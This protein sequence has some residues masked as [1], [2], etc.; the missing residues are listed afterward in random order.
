MK[1]LILGVLILISTTCFSQKKAKNP[2]TLKALS[3]KYEGDT[4][5]GLA[6]GE[7]KASGSED[8]YEGNFKKG[9][10]HGEGTYIWGNGNKY[11]GEFSKGRMNGEGELFIK[12]KNNIVSVQAGYFK[13]N[14]YLGKYKSPYK[15]LSE[16]GVRSVDF[17]E[18]GTNLNQVTFEVYLNGKMV[19]IRELE[20][21][22]DNS[23]IVADVNGYKALTN[24]VFPLK[25][26]ELSFEI[27]GTTYKVVFEIYKKADWKV[28]ISA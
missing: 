8:S 11:I 3:E 4:K 10:P 2:V 6:N 26:V 22:D 12:G 20:I 21:R 19:D 18:Q 14:E 5:K 13:D 7:G 15:V 9:L 24:T 23:S 17:Q 16:V 27:D 28:V 1:H 25:N